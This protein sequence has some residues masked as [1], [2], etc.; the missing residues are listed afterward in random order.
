MNLQTLFEMQ[1][2]LDERIVKKK[3]LEGQNL[4]SEKILALQVELGELANEWRG[5]KFWSEH[6][7]PITEAPCFMCDGEG[8]YMGCV[9]AP[10][11]ELAL[12]E[13][14]EC[15]GTGQARNPLL[16]EYVDCLHFILSIGNEFGCSE[17]NFI[18]FSHRE[19][20]VTNQFKYVFYTIS[21]ID[22]RLVCKDMSDI[23]ETFGYL[24]GGF[25][26][27]G[28]MLGFSWE[29]IEKAYIE[30]NQINHERQ[31]NGY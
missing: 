25:L 18:D 7:E 9:E 11:I 23:K 2:T 4:L 17:L 20:N 14:S 12:V 8:G 15:N 13:C 1:K 28:E 21:S 10:M 16:E 30:K 5:F 3:G 26:E 27:L 24:F 29:Q 31:N 22:E 19:S 6:R